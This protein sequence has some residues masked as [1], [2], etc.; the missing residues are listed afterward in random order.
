MRVAVLREMRA[1]LLSFLLV[2]VRAQ[3]GLNRLSDRE[4]RYVSRRAL[5]VAVLSTG[6]FFF[7]RSYCPEMLRQ[8]P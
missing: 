5:L 2:F 7:S 8:L 6:S 4:F 3:P 1:S